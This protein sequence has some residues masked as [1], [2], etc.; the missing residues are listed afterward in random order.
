VRLDRERK[1]ARS[2]GALAAFRGRLGAAWRPIETRIHTAAHR[3]VDFPTPEWYKS[4]GY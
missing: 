2:G 1:G 4:L 3:R